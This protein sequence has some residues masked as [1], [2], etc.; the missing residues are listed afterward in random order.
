VPAMML[1]APPAVTGAAESSAGRASCEQD[2]ST[3]STWPY[4]EG[5]CAAGKAR[6]PRVVRAATNPPALAAI[7]LGRPSALLENAQ[8]PAPA[9]SLPVQGQAHRSPVIPPAIAAAEASQSSAATSKKAKKVARR[10]NRRR[11]PSPREAPWWREVHA[12][13]WGVGYGGGVRDYGRGGYARGGFFGYMQCA[14]PPPGRLPMLRAP[15][16]VAGCDAQRGRPPCLKFMSTP[17][18]AARLIRNVR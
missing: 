10:E 4:L 13:P 14:A 5:K 12:D 1:A 7:A 15:A 16:I 17:S 6:K 11:D 9:V 18:K 2:N 3:Q 8:E